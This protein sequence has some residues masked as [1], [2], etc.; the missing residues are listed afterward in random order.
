MNEL[1]AATAVARDPHEPGEIMEIQMGPSHPASHGTIKFNLK[2][3]SE[4]VE[5][6]VEIGYLQPRLREMCEQ[7]TWNHCFPYAIG[8]LRLAA[9]EQRRLRLG[10]RDAGRVEVPSASCTSA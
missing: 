4:I 2:P 6:D 10:R 9:P 5:V 3:T 7:F 1:V 8:E